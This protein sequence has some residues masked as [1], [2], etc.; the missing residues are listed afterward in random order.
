MPHI[1][2]AIAL[3]SNAA[4]S[5]LSGLFGTLWSLAVLIV[6]SLCLVAVEML[7]LEPMGPHSLMAGV[8]RS[9]AGAV[10][11][12]TYLSLINMWV[13][14]KRTTLIRHLRMHTGSLLVPFITVLFFFM[15]M[16]IFA[17]YIPHP[18][19]WAFVVVAGVIVNP[20]PEVVYQERGQG[21]GTLQHAAEFMSQNWP[22]WLAMQLPFLALLAGWSAA[23][24][25]AFTLK[26]LGELWLDS[27]AR[28]EVLH[29]ASTHLRD[30]LAGDA[31]GP[32]LALTLLVMT[33]LWMLFRG[34]V[35]RELN[36]GNRRL[37][38]WQSRM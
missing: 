32:L 7:F 25:A 14:A 22:E 20:A 17:S 4:K 37:R 29:H 28:L 19:A 30:G 11:V 23:A 27:G 5:T 10:F 34:H 12:S 31:K 21:F 16:Q 9:V 15:I 38:A 35:F 33:H 36:K 24:N 6:G 18:M 1:H 8:C 3:Y 13:Q 26:D 2:A